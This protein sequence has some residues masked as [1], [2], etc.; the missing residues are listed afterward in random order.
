MVGVDVMMMS[1]RSDVVGGFELRSLS[2]VLYLVRKKVRVGGGRKIPDSSEPR[3]H[4]VT[5]H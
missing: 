5:N 4:M 3:L 2:C 1:D